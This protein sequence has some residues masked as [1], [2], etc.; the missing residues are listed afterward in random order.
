MTTIVTMENLNYNYLDL[1][2]LKKLKWKNIGVKASSSD[3]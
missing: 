3:G 2:I 1:N